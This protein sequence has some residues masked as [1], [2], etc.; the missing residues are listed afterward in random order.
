ML[1]GSGWVGGG[2]GG[3]GP[4]RPPRRGRKLWVEGGLAGR[5]CGWCGRCGSSGGV[6]GDLLPGF[7][8][9]CV[10]AGWA[11]G[12]QRKCAGLQGWDG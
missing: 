1:G 12:S 10:E 6:M 11:A 7:G 4:L 8:A 5:W 2:G 3:G 9:G